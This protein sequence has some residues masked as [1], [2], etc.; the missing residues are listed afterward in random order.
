LKPAKRIEA[1]IAQYTAR[2]GDDAEP[3]AIRRAAEL[4]QIAEDL[5]A[6]QLRGE[7]VDAGSLFQGRGLRRS[8]TAPAWVAQ[9]AAEAP[10]LA[11]RVGYPAA[12][13]KNAWAAFG[14]AGLSGG[15]P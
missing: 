4:V 13:S 12:R 11:G 10:A 2:L 15:A 8:C 6:R 9:A 14:S 7:H 5:R 1:L 3:D